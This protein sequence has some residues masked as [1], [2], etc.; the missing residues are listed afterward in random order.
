MSRSPDVTCGPNVPGSN[1][2]RST[3]GHRERSTPM[4]LALLHPGI[5]AVLETRAIS[6]LFCLFDVRVTP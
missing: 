4:A 3:E 6:S 1:C 5:E 2:V